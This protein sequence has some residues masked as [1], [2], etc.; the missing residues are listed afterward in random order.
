MKIEVFL[1][2]NINIIFAVELEVHIANSSI[3]SIIIGKLRYKKKLCPI[4]LLKVD[5]GSKID[6]HYIILFLDL[7]VYL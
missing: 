5:K 6:F 7:A 1:I 3:F 2:E 4:I